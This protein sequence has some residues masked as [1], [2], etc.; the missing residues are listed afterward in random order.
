MFSHLQPCQGRH[1]CPVPK[2]RVAFLAV[3]SCPLLATQELDT[4][5]VP[6]YVCPPK[7]LST[8]SRA[9][10]GKPM[11][12]ARGQFAAS[13]PQSQLLPVHLLQSLHWVLSHVQGCWSACF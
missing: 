7:F 10:M 8:C 12:T 2:K 13:V 3:G 1:P 5:F 9:L 4:Q 6:G 11:G